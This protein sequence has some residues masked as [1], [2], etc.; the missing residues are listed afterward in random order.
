[1]VLVN[2]PTLQAHTFAGRIS[3]RSNQSLQKSVPAQPGQR[4]KLKI[5][6]PSVKI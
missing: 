4:E 6:S 1:M 2:R 5:P 3:Q